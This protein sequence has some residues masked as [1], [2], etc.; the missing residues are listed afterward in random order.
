MSVEEDGDWCTTPCIRFKADADDDI[1]IEV[2]AEE[3]LA[4]GFV[5]EHDVIVFW[6]ELLLRFERGADPT[7]HITNDIVRFYNLHLLWEL[8]YFCVCIGYLFLYQFHSVRL[9]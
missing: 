1:G 8:V 5:V 4:D 6:S 7:L 2:C 3:L 9:Q